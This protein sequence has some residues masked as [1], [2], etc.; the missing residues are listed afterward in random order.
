MKKY[1][2]L[3]LIILLFLTAI[4]FR[5]WFITLAPQPF[6]W[7][8]DEY[9]NYAMKMYNDRFLLAAH[10]YR[11]YPWPLV[12]AIIYRIVGW[13]NHNALY[14]FNAILD[15]VTAFVIYIAVKKTVKLSTAAWASYLIYAFNPITSGYVGMGLSEVLTAFFIATSLLSGL[16]YVEQP[17]LVKG[18]LFGF[19]AGMAAETRNAAFVW[20]AVPIILTVFFVNYKKLIIPY[21]GIVLGLFMTMLYPL[22]TNWEAYHQLSVTKVDSFYAMEFYNGVTLKILPP[23]TKV[24]PPGQYVMWQEYYSEFYPGRTPADRQV[25][26]AK[27]F[28]KAWDLILADPVDYIRWRFYKMWY[29]W[30][31]E[32]V[33][34]ITEPNFAQ[35]RLITYYGNQVL[36][37][38]CAIG[39]AVGWFKYH[40]GKSRYLWLSILGT[41]GYCTF[42]FCFSHSEYRLTVPFYPVLILPA[43]V[44]LGFVLEKIK[45]F[46]LYK[47][48]PQR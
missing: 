21:I 34:F 48:T 1:K 28:K 39:L 3:I 17:S 8:Q 23:F 29:V 12:M 27:Y 42:A 45:N 36:L 43:G 2:Q 31:K 19:C 38:L 11:S 41:I 46:R 4:S 44:A 15:S 9:Q 16:F 30:Q 7:D 32:N 14:L 6:Y 37:G 35:H 24:Y 10:T 20:A 5:L 40:W 47:K 13:G 18:V 22:Y 25:M 26:A 33:F